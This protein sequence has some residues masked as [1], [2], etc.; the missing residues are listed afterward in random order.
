MCKFFRDFVTGPD[1]EQSFMFS[2]YS[3]A[4]CDKADV[5][6][7]VSVIYFVTTFALDY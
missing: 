7:S 6:R 2:S 5:G 4:K 1:V 3:I